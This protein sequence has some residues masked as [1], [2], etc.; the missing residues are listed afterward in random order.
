MWV[1]FGTKS[2]NRPVKNGIR[3]HRFCSKCGATRE[4]EEARFATY[5]TLYFIPLFPIE[6]GVPV[7]R[8]PVCDT[9]YD[10]QPADYLHG[11]RPDGSARPASASTRHQTPAENIIINC[12]QCQQKMRIPNVARTILV[13][14]PHCTKKFKVCPRPPASSV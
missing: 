4:F 2:R 9:S 7:L 13:T 8:C 10:M 3:R 5:F 1:F 14:C 11:H 12:V 6:R